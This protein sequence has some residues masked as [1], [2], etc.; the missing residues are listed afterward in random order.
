MK[1]PYAPDNYTCKHGCSIGK[2][3]II[4]NKQHLPL[5]KWVSPRYQIIKAVASMEV[6]MRVRETR[7]DFI[8]VIHALPHTSGPIGLERRLEESL[9]IRKDAARSSR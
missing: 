4:S 2:Y 8:A 3:A 5:Y 7:D 1:F 6:K 9:E